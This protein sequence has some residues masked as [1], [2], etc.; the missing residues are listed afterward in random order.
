MEWQLFPSE[1]NLCVFAHLIFLPI[2][3]FGNKMLSGIRDEEKPA[4]TGSDN[5]ITAATRLSFMTHQAEQ[6]IKTGR[7]CGKTYSTLL[8]GQRKSAR[9]QSEERWRYRSTSRSVGLKM[10]RLIHWTFSEELVFCSLARPS[11]NWITCLVQ[12][13]RVR[14]GQTAV[15]Q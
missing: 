13:L 1:L 11:L 12:E 5:W 15:C 7:G 10:W 8:S 4:L 2:R 3:Y 9:G 6:I 14:R